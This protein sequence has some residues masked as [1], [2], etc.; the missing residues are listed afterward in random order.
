MPNLGLSP[1][2]VGILLGYLEEK[3]RPMSVKNAAMP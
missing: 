3:S 2:E 1:E